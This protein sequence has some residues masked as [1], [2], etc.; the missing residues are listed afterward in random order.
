MF[1]ASPAD[2]RADSPALLLEPEAGA[3]AALPL[4][5]RGRVVGALALRFAEPQSF[6]Q[7]ERAFFGAIADQCALAMDRARLYEAERQ[8]RAEALAQRDALRAS[9]ER[10]RSSRRTCATCSG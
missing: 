2:L 10:F 4:L 1:Y 9:E 7:S 5:V 6:D 8:A 3:R